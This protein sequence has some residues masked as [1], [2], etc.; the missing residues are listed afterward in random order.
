MHDP[1]VAQTGEDLY[2]RAL[3]AHDALLTLQAETAGPMV[4]RFTRDG[5]MILHRERRR[6]FDRGESYDGEERRQAA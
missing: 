5:T 4:R 2:L 3:A 6:R 1:G